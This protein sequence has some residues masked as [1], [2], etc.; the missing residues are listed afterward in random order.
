MTCERVDHNHEHGSCRAAIEDDEA[1]VRLQQALDILEDAGA[2]MD[3]LRLLPKR[4]AKEKGLAHFELGEG[5]LDMD[6]VQY[7]E[8]T[9]E[10]AIEAVRQG[11]PGFAVY[12]G[13]E[14]YGT[15]DVL[16]IDVDDRSN[17]PYDDLPN[18]AEFVSGSGRGDHLI[19]HND[20]SV[21]NAAIDDPYEGEVRADRL[22]T[23]L[24]GS[25]HDSGGM[26]D[27][28]E[29]RDPVTLSESD[30]PEEFTPNVDWDSASDT[31]VELP[32]EDDTSG[33]EFANEH[34]ASV[35]DIREE[36]EYF[37]KL[38]TRLNPGGY[39]HDDTSRFDYH[40]VRE[41]LRWQFTDGQIARIWRRYR[42]R[43]K[44]SSHPNYVERTIRAA[45]SVSLETH[46]FNNDGSITE[47]RPANLMGVGRLQHLDHDELR[48][49]ARKRGVEWPSVED[50]REGI[51]EE[52]RQ[53]MANEE[54]AVQSA[55]TGAGKTYSVASTLWKGREEETGGQPVVHAHRTQEARDQAAATSREQDLDTYVLR[56]RKELCPV[57]AGDHDPENKKGNSDTFEIDDIPISK[58]I[59]QLC[60]V[61]GLPISV[62]HQWAEQEVAGDL[63]CERGDTTCP[64]KTQFE[65]IPRLDS[66]EVT[67][68]IIHCTHHFLHVPGLR[69]QTNVII[70][71]KPAFGTD[72]SPVRVRN[73]VNAYL[74]W[75]EA[76]FDSYTDLVMASRDGMIPAEQTMLNDDGSTSKGYKSVKDTEVVA[77]LARDM[78]AHIVLPAVDDQT[79]VNY[80]EG[81]ENDADEYEA[82]E[83]MDLLSE[84]SDYHIQQAVD[85]DRL[86]NQALTQSPPISW[87]R[88]T[89]G[90]HALAPAFARAIWNAEEVADGRLR[91]RIPYHPPRFDDQAHD[92]EAWNRC[93]VD[94][95]L[96]DQWEVIDVTSVPDFS[97][98]RSVIGL[99]AH[100]QHQDPHWQVNVSSRMETDFLLDTHER[101]LY[102]RYERG[103]FTVQVGDYT[104]PV[105]KGKW[106]DQG[107]GDRFQAHVEELRSEYGDEF[108][109]A[110]T[111]MA[112]KPHVRGAME[113]TGCDD[114]E[115][116]HYGEEESRDDFAGQSVGYTAGCIDPGDD[117]VMNLVARL[118]LD[119]EPTY[120]DC[121][122]CDG[123]GE[124][125]AGDC[126][127]CDDR[128]EKCK[129]EGEVRE[130]GRT[131]SGSDSETADAVL[132]GV[133]EH[134]VAQSV[135]RW[136][137]D[138]DDPDDT[139][140]VYV[141][142]DATPEGFID[143][144]VPG[145]TWLPSQDQ[146]D[147]IE[148]V[149][150][151]PGATAKEIADETDC[152]KQAAWDTLTTAFEKGLVERTPGVGPYGADIYYPAEF[153]PYGS[154][155]LGSDLD[156]TVSDR[157]LKYHT[158]SVTVQADPRFAVGDDTGDREGWHY[159]VPLTGHDNVIRPPG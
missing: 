65:D 9:P 89:E 58:W 62:V 116:M 47:A 122:H 129:G 20:G 132:K 153:N 52:V 102:R 61:V 8:F 135:G 76:P 57:C 55:P 82:G 2:D 104:Q 41:L 36:N 143:A 91:A 123:S 23:V 73:A 67:H 11:H 54:T 110:I 93:F 109:T 12:Y 3:R 37:D 146:R 74:E 130:S 77:D 97:L 112:A 114:P 17:F 19:Y 158:W 6:E 80:T 100:P 92:A 51:T 34:G 94:V 106:L 71:E 5:A 42:N 44:L 48:R 29:P 150:E 31:T 99:D 133:R 101:T 50:V 103:L 136:A 14:R 75:S 1:A 124:C 96:D 117:P 140:V 38:C 139:A 142:T 141:A 125:D 10:E 33:G 27:I 25:T 66:G 118:G 59:D 145:V 63:P 69:L 126:G 127:S 39:G 85:V 53:K 148:Y 156:E 64:T 107:Q 155:D 137:R 154:L 95:V 88:E 45:K 70:D 49:Y 60:D 159:Q 86:F 56:G 90:A 13:M 128:C 147:R 79:L 151:N 28:A 15:E 35:S 121:G 149:A 113:D 134:H 105:T 26:Y 4:A 81:S 144:K 84:A 21:D 43:E 120:V 98:S 108:S 111:S 131:F 7:Y 46:E 87:Y 18:T 72:I 24:P 32:P 119:A 83:L 16:A 157:V 138:A 78:P 152:S 30:L 115:L 22:Y 40:F 68:D